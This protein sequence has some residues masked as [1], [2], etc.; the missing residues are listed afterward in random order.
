MS[1]DMRKRKHRGKRKKLKSQ[2][3]LR[4][5]KMKKCLK[6]STKRKLIL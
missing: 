4:K 5:I 1:K 3:L 6:T 2:A